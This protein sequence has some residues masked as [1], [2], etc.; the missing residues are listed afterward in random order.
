ME[1]RG[2]SKKCAR[3][4]Q[5]EEL[6]LEVYANGRISL[7]P[8]ISDQLRVGFYK[9]DHAAQ[10]DL[11]EALQ[12]QELTNIIK[13][14]VKSFD[15]LKKDLVRQKQ[16]LQADY[17]QKIQAH[18]VKLYDRINDT[19]RDLEAV[20]KKKL[21]NLRSSYQQQL[22][23]ALAVI[24]EYYKNYYTKSPEISPPHGKHNISSV[25]IRTLLGVLNE[26]EILIKSLEAQILELQE[27]EPSKQIIY[28][29]EDDPEKERI[30]EEN[31]ELKDEVETLQEKYRQLE[32]ILIQKEK[33]IHSLDLDVGAMKTKME[34][35]QKT[36]EKLTSAQEQLKIEFENE[37]SASATMLQKQKEE[38]EMGIK[39][40]IQEKE[41]E[42]Q[43][44]REELETG[45]RLTMQEKEREQARLQQEH[46]AK[47]LEEMERHKQL[48]MLEEQEQKHVQQREIMAVNTE[49]LSS[50]QENL[51]SQI[52]KLLAIKEEHEKTIQRLQRELERTNKTWEKKLE[53]LK[54]SFH[55]IK[56]EMFLRQSLHRQAMNLH[57][58]SV[59]Y[60]TEGTFPLGLPQK[61]S[62]YLST[63]PL[64]QIGARSPPPMNHL[65]ST[66]TNEQEQ[67]I[68]NDDELQV[69]SDVEVDLED[70]PSLPPP[71]PN[72]KNSE[73]INI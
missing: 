73:L 50:D 54:Q 65:I 28:V 60:M 47:M 43:K 14:L 6:S 25:D 38:L 22:I 69:V 19:V 32:D 34:K 46:E 15:I 26:K 36:I 51:L 20:H 68:F 37:K 29:S 57:K 31:K 48:L 4:F 49:I 71:P 56:D 13:T 39:S 59:S 2:V 21:S 45:L 8:S 11:S 61:S 64:P 62:F 9:A 70:V 63:V 3:D 27:Q 72:K 16:I 52:K 18:A 33:H 7:R 24:K 5:D 35:D 1:L 58:V 30:Q 17:E 67:N 44:Q 53:I 55:A 23:D 10:T 12:L 42:L 66:Y 41:I 40:K